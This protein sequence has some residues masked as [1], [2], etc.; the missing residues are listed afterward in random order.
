MLRRARAALEQE[1]G[2]PVTQPEA[3]RMYLAYAES[4]RGLGF[5]EGPPGVFKRERSAVERFLV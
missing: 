1:L 5:T 3:K 4:L 2:R